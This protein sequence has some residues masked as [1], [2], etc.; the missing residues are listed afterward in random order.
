MKLYIAEKPSLGKGIAEYLPGQKS[1]GNGFIQCG[2]DVVTWCFGH[3]FEQEEPD[4]YTPDTVPVTPKGKKKWR[5]EELPIFPGQWKRRPKDDAK[6]QIKVIR[7]LL[8]KASVVVNA[9][10]PDRE[11]QLLVDEV[12]EELGWK[13]KTERIWLAALDEQSVKKALANLKNNAEYQNLRNSAE[14]RSRA[15][16]LTGMNLTR[17][18]T[19][20]NSGSGVVSVGRVQTPTLALVVARDEKIERFKPKD[21]YVPRIATGFWSA[22]EKRDELV[23]AEGYLTDKAIADGLVTKAKASG[24]ATVIGY[25][26]S[27]KKQQAPLGY[28]LAELQKVCSAK[29]GLSAQQVLDAAQELYETHKCATYPRTDCRYL[30]EEQHGEAGRVLSGLAKL[31]FTDLT[32]DADASQKSAI[33]NTGKVTAHHAIIPTGSMQGSLSGA[34]AKVFELIVRSYLAQFYPPYVFRATKVVLDCAGE[35]WKA[36]ANVPV[37]PG[38]KAVYGMEV[39]GEDGEEDVQTIPVLKKG[40]VLPITGADVQSKQTKPPARFTDGTL[41]EA[42]SNI[43]KIVDD[44]EAKAKLK[45][46]SGLGTEA[47]RANTLETLVNRGFIE[48][49]GKQILSTSAGRAVVKAL[50]KELIDP[51][52]TAR[53]EDALGAIASGT[54]TLEKFES[55]QRSFV[56]KMI[57]TAKKTTL[58]IGEARKPV[59]GKGGRKAGGKGPGCSACKKATVALKTKKGSVFFKCEG[60]QSCWWPDK[61]DEKKL[62]TKWEAR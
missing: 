17:A 8:K 48:R 23:D 4:F 40:Q 30:P 25:E 37:K 57:E 35:A 41:I 46:T 22:W 55:L 58:A 61:Q 27:E 38:W 15:D 14:A 28:S 11:G 5:F 24:T 19:L 45:E 6:A 13:G 31:G 59:G 47:T 50:P 10:D 9:G 51:V 54:V 36:T 34:A 49:K 52:L 21:F 60:C 26:S 29:L 62:G 3:I 56:E 20:R 32:K 18:Y 43:H 1:K 33:W 42:M 2:S 53:W 16:W 39:S 12:L 44:P 7:D